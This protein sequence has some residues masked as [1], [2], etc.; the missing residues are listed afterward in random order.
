MKKTILFLIAISI[1]LSD[2]ECQLW[3]LRR[4]E[5]TVSPGITYFRGDIGGFP[6]GESMMGLKNVSLRQSGLNLSAGIRYRLLQNFSVRANVATGLFQSSDEHGAFISR[7]YASTTTFLEPALLGE[8]YI[9]RNKLENSYL[10]LRDKRRAHQPF[11]SSIDLYFFTGV[12]GIFY[13][14]IPNTNLFPLA[15][16]RKGLAAM[17]PAGFGVARNIPGNMSLGIEAGGRYVFSDEIDD[18]APPGSNKG[19]MYYFIN[20]IATW[21]VKTRRFPV[22]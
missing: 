19:D 5:V 18:F 6:K 3:R 12:G 7:N 1:F 20:F 22:F 16:E 8:F 4:T 21:K 11:M 15:T 9:L 14:A 13:D 2:G 10:F 17:I